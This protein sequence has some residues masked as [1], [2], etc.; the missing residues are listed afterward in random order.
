[1]LPHQRAPPV[2]RQRSWQT[3]SRGDAASAGGREQVADA[4]DPNPAA[5]KSRLDD[6]RRMYLWA[7]GAKTPTQLLALKT[8]A[9][10]ARARAQEATERVDNLK[11]QRDTVGMDLVIAEAYVHEQ[12]QQQQQQ[13]ELGD[14]GGEEAAVSNEISRE[15]LK[16]TLS[17]V[18]LLQHQRGKVLQSIEA[19]QRAAR[20][21]HAER[22]AAI[23]AHE[24]AVEKDRQLRGEVGDD[25][26]LVPSLSAQVAAA[27]RRLDAMRNQK[28]SF[29]AALLRAKSDQ[30]HYTQ[31]MHV[32]RATYSNFLGGTK[33]GGEVALGNAG[34]HANRNHRGNEAEEGGDAGGDAGGGDARGLSGGAPGKKR[35]RGRMM[36]GPATRVAAQAPHTARGTIE[37]GKNAQGT[38][39]QGS[40]AEGMEAHSTG[41]QGSS[42]EGTE[43]QGT[44]GSSAE[45]VGAEG[46]DAEGV[47]TEG[48]DAEGERHERAFATLMSVQDVRHEFAL[49]AEQDKINQKGVRLA[50]QRVKML[51]PQIEQIDARIAQCES[52]LAALVEADDAA[53]AGTRPAAAAAA[54]AAS[55][56]ERTRRHS[57]AQVTY[58]DFLRRMRDHVLRLTRRAC[59]LGSDDGGQIT[60]ARIVYRGYAAEPNGRDEYEA[61]YEGELFRNTPHG[62]GVMVQSIGTVFE[63]WRGV[64]VMGRLQSG[65]HEKQVVH[66]TRPASKTDTRNTA[67]SLAPLVAQRSS[68]YS[69]P[70]GTPTPPVDTSAAAK[71]GILIRFGTY[72]AVGADALPPLHA[73]FSDAWSFV[74]PRLVDGFDVNISID[75]LTNVCKVSGTTLHGAAARFSSGKGSRSAEFDGNHFAYD[76]SGD[77]HVRVYYGPNDGNA[78]ADASQAYVVWH[79][80]RRGAA[81]D[82]IHVQT[83]VIDPNGSAIPGHAVTLGFRAA[84]PSLSS[85]VLSG[86]AFV[87]GSSAGEYRGQVRLGVPHGAGRHARGGRAGERAGARAGGDGGVQCGDFECRDDNANEAVD[88]QWGQFFD[89]RFACGLSQNAA[90]VGGTGAAQQGVWFWGSWLARTNSDWVGTAGSTGAQQ[91]TG[92]EEESS[93]RATSSCWFAGQHFDDFD[94]ASRHSDKAAA[95]M[96]LACVAHGHAAKAVSSVKWRG[97]A[98]PEPPVLPQAATHLGAPPQAAAPL[99]PL[100]SLAS[101]HALTRTS[102]SI[103]GGGSK[104]DGVQPRSS[105]AVQQVQTAPRKEWRRKFTAHMRKLVAKG[106]AAKTTRDKL[107]VCARAVRLARHIVAAKRKYPASESVQRYAFRLADVLSRV[108]THRVSLGQHIHSLCL[109]LM[110]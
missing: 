62:K 5:A 95:C 30:M 98:L 52:Q 90:R 46:M 59:V 15:A 87:G 26:C 8:S 33:D 1:M 104:K 53:R 17:K 103:Q 7:C 99:P 35:T 81:K 54:A 94:W 72:E 57:G 84:L 36:G 40:S 56:Q 74:G 18:A 24:E 29:E 34:S 78:G 88:V 48:V 23:I 28:Q 83:G 105:A 89:G 68:R 91:H 20:E 43:A 65:W 106:A 4:A 44:Q 97:Q 3:P 107:A 21:R 42:A 80:P 49:A 100:R 25:D 85:D 102:R 76:D 69:I 27:R 10:A 12:Q 75:D 13:A 70:S 67:S 66:E 71:T 82:D 14:S 39:T 45:G 58:E 108:R 55:A 93:C 31:K 51:V 2:S 109:A 32:F 9:D 37:E 38:G 92:I 6:A 110:W 96:Q 64:W 50:A 11:R 86:A 47:D 79:F 22:E 101:N 73:D 19:A 60:H 61:V 63:R 77:A 41:T 16:L